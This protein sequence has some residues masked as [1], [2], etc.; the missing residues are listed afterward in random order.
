MAR[1]TQK[2]IAAKLGLS[3]S[4]VSRALSGKAE[5][6]GCTPETTTRIVSTARALGY[7]PSAA[8]RQLRGG[9]GPVIGVVVSDMGD[10]FFAQVMTEVI[11][12]A[13]A[14]GYA[15]AVAGL[16]RRMIDQRDLSLLLEQ[17]LAGLLMIGGGSDAGLAPVRRRNL[18]AV[19]IGSILRAAPF[20]QVGPDEAEGFR[21]L[22]HHLA[23]LGHQ[24]LGFVGADQPVHR[25]RIRLAQD[26]AR[27]R[28]LTWN[29]RH[30]VYGPAEVL[31]AGLEGGR[32]LLDQAGA[33]LPSACGV[34]ER[35]R[36]DGRDGYLDQ[37]R[38]A[39]SP[40]HFH[41]RFRRPSAFSI[42]LAA[43][44]HIA[45]ARAGNDRVGA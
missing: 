36:G 6:I 44:D 32:R 33:M 9:G 19:R 28:G 26:I 16:D 39:D 24:R 20:A 4:L 30:V 8:A 17:D 10:P 1:V 37:L 21:K 11:R 25:E 3:P 40:R 45:S 23:T 43:V 7:V 2:T 15:L 5:A 41:H 13:H 42:G 35:Y 18:P 14:R 27:S 34:F 22:V 12:Q 38:N 31:K 29:R